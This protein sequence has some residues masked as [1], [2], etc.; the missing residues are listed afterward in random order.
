[1]LNGNKHFIII[2]INKTVHKNIILILSIERPRYIKQCVSSVQY[3]IR[4]L[5]Y[6]NNILSTGCAII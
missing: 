2:C 4:E 6:F 1:M 5:I 3:E